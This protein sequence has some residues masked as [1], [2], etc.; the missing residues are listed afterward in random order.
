MFFSKS[1]TTQYTI[2]ILRKYG[3]RP[4][5]KMGQNFLIEPRIAEQQVNFAEIINNEK[6]LEI[7]GGIGVLSYQIAKRAGETII[8]EKDKRL[9]EHLIQLFKS[10][11]NVQIICGDALK[12]KLPKIDK[13]VS[14]LPYSIS[15]DIIFKLIEE[16]DFKIAV[17]M[18]QEEFIE[19]LTAKPGSEKYGRLAIGVNRRCDIEIQRKVS[20]F[21]FYPVPKVDSSIIKLKRKKIERDSDFEIIFFETVKGI[22]NFPRKTL[23]SAINQWLKRRQEILQEILTCNEISNLFDKRVRHLTSKD[24]EEI[25][26]C[27]QRI[28]ENGKTDQFNFNR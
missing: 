22:F 13:V 20:K 18:L 7:G 14:N 16:T 9:C 21:S 26:K 19:R 3:I 11:E 27:I 28:L 24:F 10:H 25:A 23:R 17:L 2:Q 15:S 12:I 5:K 8:I 4:S 6:V 1:Q